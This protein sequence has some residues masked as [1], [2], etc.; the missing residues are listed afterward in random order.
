MELRSTSE[1]E[2]TFEYCPTCSGDLDTGWECNKCG[3]DWIEYAYPDDTIERKYRTFY[4]R[5]C[6]MHTHK[7]STFLP[8]ILR[9][10]LPKRL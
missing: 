10:I 8:T 6:Q 9:R 3:L 2:R 5:I 1:M 7:Y 4:N